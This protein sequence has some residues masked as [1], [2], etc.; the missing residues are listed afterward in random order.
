MV[1]LIEPHDRKNKQ[2]RRDDKVQYEL[3]PYDK[4]RMKLIFEGQKL[5]KAYQETISQLENNT[6]YQ[7]RKRQMPFLK[8]M[9]GLLLEAIF[10]LFFIYLFLLLI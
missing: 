6:K 2:F 10:M 5:F 1:N 7:P 8:N 4:V 9:I 3:D